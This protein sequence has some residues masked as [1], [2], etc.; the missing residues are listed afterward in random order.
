MFFSRRTFKF[1]LRPNSKKYMNRHM[2]IY[3]YTYTYIK[4]RI[5]I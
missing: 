3:V 1:R 5:T 2:Y 4:I